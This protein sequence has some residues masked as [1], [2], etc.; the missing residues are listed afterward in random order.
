MFCERCLPGYKPEYDDAKGGFVKKCNVI[1]N[2]KKVGK[3]YNSCQECKAGYV[4]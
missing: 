4:H 1:A 2:C 3:M